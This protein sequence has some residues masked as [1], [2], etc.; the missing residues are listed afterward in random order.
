MFFVELFKCNIE[1]FGTYGE[2]NPGLIPACH[3]NY[4]WTIRDLNP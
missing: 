1:N 2:S 3:T 4:W